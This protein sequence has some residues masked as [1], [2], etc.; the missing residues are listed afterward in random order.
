VSECIITGM[1]VIHLRPRISRHAIARYRQRV[2]PVDAATA[3]DRLA[4]LAAASTRRPIPRRWTE[5]A[6]APGLLFLYPHDEP[7]VCLVMKDNTIVT[8][9]ARVICLEWRNGRQPGSPRG[10]RRPPYKRPS[11]GSWPREA[12]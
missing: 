10:V 11:P 2:E 7:D 5:V 9:F 12:A 8:V 4:E 6:P 1:Q 3:A